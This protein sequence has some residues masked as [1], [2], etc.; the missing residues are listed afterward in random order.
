V[1]VR[2]EKK[3]ICTVGS[4]RERK[5]KYALLVVEE[6]ERGNMHCSPLL[7]FIADDFLIICFI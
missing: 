7:V 4:I 1:V 2:R 5:W 6:R 3:K